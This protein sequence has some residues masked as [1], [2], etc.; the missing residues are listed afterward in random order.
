MQAEVLFEPKTA[1]DG[2]EDGLDFYRAIIR[3]WTPKLKKGGALVFELGE[4][5]AETVGEMMIKHGFENIR[6]ET[7]FGGGER[8][9]IGFLALSSGR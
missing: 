3:D 1:L 2:G 8:A 7:D 4:D 9:I 6:T 5:Q